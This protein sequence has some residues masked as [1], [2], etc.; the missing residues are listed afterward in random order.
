MGHAARALHGD[1]LACTPMQSTAKCPTLYS[2]K[3]AP[4]VSHEKGNER[5]RAALSAPVAVDCGIEGRA[6]GKHIGRVAVVTRLE[7]PRAAVLQPDLHL[8]RED[9]HP[10]R[11][12]RAV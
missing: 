5:V 9:K 10:L 4:S 3:V 11:P 2:E 8:S 1:S 7:D 6:R 12:R